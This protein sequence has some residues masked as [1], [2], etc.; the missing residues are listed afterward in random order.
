[1][2]PQRTIETILD[3]T[4]GELIESGTFFNETVRNEAAIFQLRTDIEK[5]IQ[6]NDIRH[7]CIFCKQPVALRGRSNQQ[8]RV[9]T[10]YFTHLYN[11]D[12]CV[13]KTNHRLTEEQVR[14]I[15]YN[16][17]KESILHE[18][19]KNLIARYLNL[20]TS[21]SD[22]R[23]EKTYKDL[24]ISKDWRKPDVLAVFGQHK[25]AFELQLSTTFLSVIVGRTLFY[26]ERNVFLLWV[27]PHFSLDNDIQK[28]TQKDVYYNNAF[29]VYV[30]DHD[31]QLQSE[32]HGKLILK[33]F[34]Q[35]FYIQ[36]DRVLHRWAKSFIGL[37]DLEFNP[38][39]CSLWYKDVEEEK[40]ALEE[41]L[42]EQQE[43][44]KAGEHRRTV[45]GRV[46]RARQYLREY[47]AKDSDPVPDPEFCPL[48][49]IVS[50][51]EI[52]ELD[53][54]LKFTSENA[55]VIASLFLDGSKP[56]FLR[57]L[58][59]QDN[60]RVNLSKVLIS[61]KTVLA[62]L[63]F[64]EQ[65]YTFQQSVS[66]L[67][68]MGYCLNDQDR[69]TMESL[70]EKNEFNISEWEKQCISRW[71]FVTCLNSL[72]NKDYA[73]ALP[74]M[75]TALN[76][77]MSLK[78]NMIIGSKLQSLR[79]VSMNFFE[80]HKGFGAMYIKAM[81]HFGQYEKQ[82]SEDKNGKLSAKIAAFHKNT[83]AQKT[84]YNNI[85]YEIFPDL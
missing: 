72:W 7:V 70:F 16:G 81:K 58:C 39:D 34:Y 68:R 28:F 15:K 46:S 55:A 13:V 85:L 80:F 65:E 43:Q 12:D 36:R 71:S 77:F 52:E 30:F 83:P 31:A 61:G 21:V 57:F 47:Y 29:H 5:R 84:E 75:R 2:E 49:Y 59:E 19:L 1:M 44:E 25:I 56:R 42:K 3:I 64:V 26:Q 78:H 4:T 6:T 8:T 35:E 11:S 24:A 76:V 73:T 18:Q 45:E 48:Q 38:S 51:D 40:K 62:H 53:R 17:E 69:Q 27:F 67:F 54:Q 9:K 10:F 23:V 66:Q 82:L 20:D 79:Q 14:C 37:T 41:A 63:L 60:V 22:V 74:E 33:C 50:N 32:Q